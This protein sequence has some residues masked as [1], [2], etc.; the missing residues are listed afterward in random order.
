MFTDWFQ[1]LGKKNKYD[2][3]PNKQVLKLN[4]Q[5]LV[6]RTADSIVD[7]CRLTCSRLVYAITVLTSGVKVFIIAHYFRSYETLKSFR[8]N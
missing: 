7:S 2:M 5:W 6:F 4:Q 1:P 3:R 8:V